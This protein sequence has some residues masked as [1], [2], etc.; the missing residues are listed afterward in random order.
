MVVL[1][2]WWVPGLS[3]GLVAVCD[4]AWITLSTTVR[5][6]RVP[7][8]LMG[9]VL[10]FLHLLSTAAMPLGAVLGGLLA[11]AHDP[12][13]VFA[14]AAPT[15]GGEVLIARFSAIHRL[16]LLQAMLMESDQEK[17]LMVQVLPKPLAT[18]IAP[19]IVT[20]NN[21]D[22]DAWNAMQMEA[23]E[24]LTLFEQLKRLDQAC[25]AVVQMICDVGENE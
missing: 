4:T 22:A 18:R 13:L 7:G 20:I 24:N 8:S 21:A 6:E 10:S 2:W 14:M 5:Q 16:K 19:Q 3:L 9:W 12:C 11:Q 25:Q 1:P 17:R 15:K 23:S